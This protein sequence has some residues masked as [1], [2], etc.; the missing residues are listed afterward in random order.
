VSLTV[1]GLDIF[2]GGEAI[3]RG[4]SFAVEPGQLLGVIGPNGGGKTTVLRA[5]LGLVPVDRERIRLG[6]QALSPAGHRVAYV[7]QQAQVDW[8]YPITVLELVRQAQAPRHG[9][10]HRWTAGARQ[11]LEQAL[12]D[13]DMLGQSNKP[14]NQLSGGQRQ[15]AML[16]RALVAEAELVLLDE[17]FAGVDLASQALIWAVLERMRGE[18]R[19][20]LLV[21]HDLAELEG[22]DRLL[23]VSRRGVAFGTPGAVLQG[24]MFERAFGLPYGALA[25]GRGRGRARDQDRDHQRGRERERD[26]EREHDHEL[27]RDRAEDHALR[28]PHRAAA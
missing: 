8:D 26:H 14:V 9:G 1:R 22:A 25:Q 15:R 21:H 13:V 5:L 4:L 20:L 19:H 12:A 10:W 28:R 23:L 18:G 24:P 2:L 17:P 3:V 11:Q 27:E 6:G 7:P 16:A